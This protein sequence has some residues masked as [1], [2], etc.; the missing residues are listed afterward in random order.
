MRLCVQARLN[1]QHRV[2]GFFVGFLNDCFSLDWQ[3]TKNVTIH[4]FVFEIQML[5]RLC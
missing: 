3:S 1:K 5:A 2:W 4:L